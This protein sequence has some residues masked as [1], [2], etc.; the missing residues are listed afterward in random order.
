MYLSMG[1]ERYVEEDALCNKLYTQNQYK[2][3]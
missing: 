3:T 2:F 1:L